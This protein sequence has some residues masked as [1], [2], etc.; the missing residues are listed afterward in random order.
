MSF[1]RNVTAFKE[2]STDETRMLEQPAQTICTNIKQIFGTDHFVNNGA[3]KYDL[4]RGAR[5]CGAW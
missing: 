5:S 4:E 1:C 3:C 2:A